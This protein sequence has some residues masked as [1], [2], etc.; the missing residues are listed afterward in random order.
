MLLVLEMLTVEA[1]GKDHDE[2][3]VLANRVERHTEGDMVRAA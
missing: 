2:Y 3:E 1:V